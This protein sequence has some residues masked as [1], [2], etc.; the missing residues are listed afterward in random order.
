MAEALA[1]EIVPTR[2]M[3]KELSRKGARVLTSRR[4]PHEMLLFVH[5]RSRLERVPYGVVGII[6]PWN[7]PFSVPVPEIAAA[8]LAGNGVLFNPAP[9]AILVGRRIEGFFNAVGFPPDLIQTLHLLDREAHYLTAHPGLDKLI[10]TGSTTVGCRVMANAAG[11]I[12]P[13]LLELGGKDPAIVAADA[14]VVR[15]ARGIIWG[16]FF[17]AG[18]VC[19]SMYVAR[20]VAEP[21]LA[22]C[23]AEIQQLCIGDPLDP[24]TDIGPLSWVEPS[25]PWRGHKQSAIGATHA[26][27]GLLE[28]SRVKYISYDRGQRADNLW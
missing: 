17:N 20:S 27:L 2:G 14:D 1:A 7:F 11:N 6:A 4:R 3:L 23:L 19:A 10:F 21:F 13:V 5:K 8:L 9:H 24:Q 16:A 12:V 22:A 28:M 26:D 15:A 18:Q 25:A